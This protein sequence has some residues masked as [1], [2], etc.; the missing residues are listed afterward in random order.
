MLDIVH[1]LRDDPRAIAAV[2]A[3]TAAALREVTLHQ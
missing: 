2:H 1:G 3:L